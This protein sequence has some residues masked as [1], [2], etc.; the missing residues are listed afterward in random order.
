MPEVR[1]EQM[2][3]NPIDI[4]SCDYRP[5]PWLPDWPYDAFDLDCPYRRGGPFDYFGAGPLDNHHHCLMFRLREQF[6]K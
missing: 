5:P 4:R 6:V 3:T 2:V 1:V